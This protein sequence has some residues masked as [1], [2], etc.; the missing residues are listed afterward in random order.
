MSRSAR[1]AVGLAVLMAGGVAAGMGF[2]P[3]GAR[4][5][6]PAAVEETSRAVRAR[7]LQSLEALSR[8]LEPKAAQ[9]ARVPEIVAGLDSRH[10]R[11]HVPGS[12]RDRGVVGPHACGVPAHGR[13]SPAASV[14]ATMGPEKLP[15][16]DAAV[17]SRAR[18]QE[19]GSGLIGGQGRA[20]L[21]AAALVGR[22]KRV[23]ARS[24]WCSSA[25]CSTRRASVRS[26]TARATGSASATGGTCSSRPARASSGA[27]SRASGARGRAYGA[28][29][30]VATAR[31]CRSAKGCG[32]GQCSRRRRPRPGATRPA[33]RCG[34]RGGLLALAGLVLMM[35]P[36]GKADS[37]TARDGEVQHPPHP[38]PR[39]RS[40]R[41]PPASGTGP[42]PIGWRCPTRPV[43]SLARPADGGAA[44]LPL[45]ERGDGGRRRRPRPGA[46]RPTRWGATRCSSGS[47]RAGW[48]RS[49]SRRRTGR[50]GS[51]GTSWSSGCT[52]TWP[53]AKRSS[54][55][56]SMRPGCRRA[57]CTRTSSRSIDFGRAG[58][59]YFLALEYIPGRDLEK[60]LQRHLQVLGEPLPLTLV[61]YT[62]HAVLEALAYAHHR[63]DQEGKPM[64][65]VHR[66][67]SPGNVLVSLP[68]ARSSCPTSASSRRADTGSATPRSGW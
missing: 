58:E 38:P 27:R 26:P 48:Q 59:E 45:A 30:G 14:L 41:R 4:G 63:V 24:R 10:R 31:R 44:A 51:S 32:S 9:A 13:W 21:V 50:R 7:N 6:D 43:Q 3:G 64:E 19:L 18:E 35:L 15:L 16:A 5:P 65:I 42:R 39:R 22:A 29:P 62:M 54:P 28:R 46:R 33:W 12:L 17:M 11:P 61:F 23:S 67:V 20:Y 1:R 8:R 34:A 60:L 37:N 2:L 56:S 49:T 47:A 40:P 57:S 52:R 66:D 53:P 36:G 68:A 25:R 55:S